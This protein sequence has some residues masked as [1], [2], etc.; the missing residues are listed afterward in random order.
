MGS[1][2]GHEGLLSLKWLRTVWRPPP[3][4]PFTGKDAMR[5]LEADGWVLVTGPPSEWRVYLHPGTGRNAT[6]N[7]EWSGFWEGDLIFLTLCGQMGISRQR[8]LKLLEAARGD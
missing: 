3:K 5:T 7:T 8:L 2:N 6:I 1:G 4:G